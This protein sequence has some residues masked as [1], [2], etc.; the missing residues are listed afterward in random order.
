M[1]F[2]TH[3]PGPW[4]DCSRSKSGLLIRIFGK[5][6]FIGSIGGHPCALSRQKIEAN[7]RLVSNAPAMSLALEMI[8]VGVARFET[9]TGEFCFGG[10]RYMVSDG[11]WTGL[12]DLI[13]WIKAE[14][15][16]IEALVEGAAK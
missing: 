6:Q 5:T 3:T 13:G 15:S 7:A 9:S 2:C 1:S 4:D 10:L 8:R 11:N 14:R 12:F 16:V